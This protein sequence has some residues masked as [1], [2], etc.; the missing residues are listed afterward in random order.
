MAIVKK[1]GNESDTALNVQISTYNSYDDDVITI[2]GGAYYI[3][4]GRGNDT[5]KIVD[6]DTSRD[7]KTI[8][9]GDYRGGV[10]YDILDFSGVTNHGG[11]TVSLDLQDF[12]KNS[13]VVAANTIF[14]GFEEILGSQG[15]DIIRGSNTAEIIY[16]GSGRDILDGRGG[17]DR[18][19]GGQGA[20]FLNGGEGNDLLSGGNGNDILI[21]GG[22]NDRIE[23]G[24][25]DDIID[26]Q[27]GTI[28]N[29]DDWDT[30][31]GGS[32]SDQIIGVENDTHKT[33]VSLNF[34]GEQLGSTVNIYYRSED[35][36]IPNGIYASLKWANELAFTSQVE[37]YSNISGFDLSGVNADHATVDLRN[38][39]YSFEGRTACGNLFSG[40]GTISGVVD[41]GG[42][43]GDDT[44]IAD[45]HDNKIIVFSGTDTVFSGAGEDEIIVTKGANVHLN[46]NSTEEIGDTILGFGTNSTI[47]LRNVLSDLREEFGGGYESINIQLSLIERSEEYYGKSYALFSG[48]LYAEVKLNYETS[49]YIDLAHFDYVTPPAAQLL[50]N[51]LATNAQKVILLG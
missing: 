24:A 6:G 34:S 27:L 23:A 46:Y 21:G 29:Y 3:G 43:L 4:F 25:G 5:L 40:H 41:A 36:Y 35:V 2:S 17:D 48:N 11:V 47:D 37:N 33:W 45:D 14:F 28:D 38:G 51:D 26:L 1:F 50:Q 44:I 49:T 9:S 22:G 32:G 15:R 13:G 39:T 42:S 16:G 31:L 18:L 12:S 8:I 7:E 19:F 20:D 10:G 30:V